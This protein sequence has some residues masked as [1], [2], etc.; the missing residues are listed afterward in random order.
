MVTTHSWNLP[1]LIALS[2]LLPHCTS[3]SAF[4]PSLPSHIQPGAATLSSASARSSSSPLSTLRMGGFPKSFPNLPKQKNKA[5]YVY[6]LDERGCSRKGNEYKGKKSGG[7]DDQ[8]CVQVQMQTVEVWSERVTDQLLY[9]LLPTLSPLN[10][11]KLGL[12]PAQLPKITSLLS[13]D[14]PFLG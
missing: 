9:E 5:P 2:A 1:L 3:F 7:I 11:Y 13:D 10:R 14:G 4:P 8:M 6:L 12:P